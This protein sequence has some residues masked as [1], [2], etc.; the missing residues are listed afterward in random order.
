MPHVETK[1]THPSPLRRGDKSC[2]GANHWRGLRGGLRLHD[3]G[4][5][6][7]ECSEGALPQTLPETRFKSEER[8]AEGAE[9]D[10]V[11]DQEARPAIAVTKIRESPD[12]PW[13]IRVRTVGSQT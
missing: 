8:H 7:L 11:W 6:D 9:G 5:G 2:V 12:I 3:V 10:R 1:H 4:V 13:S